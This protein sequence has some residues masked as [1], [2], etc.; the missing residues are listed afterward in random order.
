MAA[1][2]PP[3]LFHSVYRGWQEWFISISNVIQLQEFLSG[4][5]SKNRVE[6][7]T[8]MLM[9]SES[10]KN[11]NIIYSRECYWSKMPL[12]RCADK[13]K[14]NDIEFTFNYIYTDDSFSHDPPF[15][16]QPIPGFHM[17]G[18]TAGIGRSISLQ[19]KRNTN[20]CRMESPGQNPVK[21]GFFSLLRSKP[22]WN[23]IME[24]IVPEALQ[25]ID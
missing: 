20:C 24:E 9:T 3:A 2:N 13:E 10:V 18:V 6:S 23:C 14:Q 5:N 19:A 8:I 22:G 17:G 15:P 4:N 12:Y 16:W 21:I 1:D 25:K 7:N 11:I